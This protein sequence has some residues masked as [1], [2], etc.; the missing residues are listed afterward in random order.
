MISEY[1]VRKMARQIRL[2][3]SASRNYEVVEFR[4]SRSTETTDVEIAHLDT[5]RYSV[6]TMEV[7]EQELQGDVP[8]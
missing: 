4:R 7:T 8:R 5:L 1:S 2:R 3:H 6:S